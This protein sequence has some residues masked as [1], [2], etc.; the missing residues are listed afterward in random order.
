MVTGRLV[1]LHAGVW[2][3]EHLEE[4]S[5]IGIVFLQL[6]DDNAQLH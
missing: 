3:G 6:L 4:E 1:G 5:K 2:D